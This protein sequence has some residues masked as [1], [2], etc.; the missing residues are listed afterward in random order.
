[1]EENGNGIDETE[2]E[3]VNGSEHTAKVVR[4]KDDGTDEQI[5]KT[6]SYT[7]SVVCV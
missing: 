5:Y 6:R 3:E 2:G 7:V 4:D 1:M